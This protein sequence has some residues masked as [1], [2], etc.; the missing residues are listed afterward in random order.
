MQII[1]ELSLLEVFSDPARSHQRRAWHFRVQGCGL[2]L[3]ILEPSLLDN[4][5]QGQERLIREIRL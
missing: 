4:M 5:F 3:L 1:P 2:I